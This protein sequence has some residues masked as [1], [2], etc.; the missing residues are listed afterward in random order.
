M[1]EKEREEEA[2]LYN[3]TPTEFE[4]TR[5]SDV[6]CVCSAV[7]EFVCD[8]VYNITMSLIHT[9]VQAAVFQ[10]VLRQEIAFFDATPTGNHVSGSQLL[11][12]ISTRETFSYGN[13]L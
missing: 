6:L 13:K 7:F 1:L 3:P 9:S 11:H 2:N 8:L 10:A 12:R 5:Q 4:R